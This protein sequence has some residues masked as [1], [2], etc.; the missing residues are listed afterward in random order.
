MGTT[1]MSQL[2]PDAISCLT[3]TEE[4]G[5]VAP[6]L[7]LRAMILEHA[8]YWHGRGTEQH[9]ATQRMLRDAFFVPSH[10]WKTSTL[11]R[12]QL[13]IGQALSYLGDKKNV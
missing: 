7:V 9:V 4:F 13:A 2:F 12:G 6:E 5:T 10:E 3:T 8:A 11:R 1:D